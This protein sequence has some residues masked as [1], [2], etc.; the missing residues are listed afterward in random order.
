MATELFNRIPLRISHDTIGLL[1]A[2]LGVRVFLHFLKDKMRR[3]WL[4]DKLWLVFMIYLIFTRLSGFVLYPSLLQNLSIYTFLA[5]P[6]ENGWLIGLLASIIY[7]ACSFYRTRM[8]DR[9]TL[10]LSSL[11]FVFGSILYF[12]YRLSYDLNPYSLEDEIRLVAAIIILCLNWPRHLRQSFG[13]HPERI[14]L[15]T[16]MMLL[17]TSIT[18]PHW[19]KLWVFGPGQWVDIILILGSLVMEGLSDVQKERTA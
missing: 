14:G 13:H 10:Y 17:V 11:A 12:A 5:Q 6:P 7:M 4:I 9:I 19:D 1:L 16:G 15:L 3:Q 2:A 8:S 18:V